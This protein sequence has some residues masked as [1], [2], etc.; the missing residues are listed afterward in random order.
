M[1]KVQWRGRRLLE[2]EASSFFT[3]PQRVTPCQV[4]HLANA[5][6]SSPVESENVRNQHKSITSKG[7][8]NQ[9][10][11]LDG[12]GQHNTKGENVF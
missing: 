11:S 7:K 3:W 5:G 9:G 1:M 6:C 8:N 2:E 4:I 10:T 12:L